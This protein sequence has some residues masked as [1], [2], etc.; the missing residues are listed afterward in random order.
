MPSNS[1]TEREIFVLET[2]TIDGLLDEAADFGWLYLQRGALLRARMPLPLVSAPVDL[3]DLLDLLQTG[4]GV[5]RELA[6]VVPAP[7]VLA[8][9]YDVLPR[10]S[11]GLTSAPGNE[12]AL[13]RGYRA[14]ATATARAELVAFRDAISTSGQ[15]RLVL[16]GTHLAAWLAHATGDRATAL[17]EAS[18]GA[19]LADACGFGRSRSTS[20]C[21]GR[22]VW[23]RPVTSRAPTG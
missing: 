8:A 10:R 15:P 16:A 18:R 1:T 12:H 22:V 11:G 21:C 5:H 13:V 19:E 23:S 14:V 9:L 7:G 20:A 4:S 3:T 17:H 2:Q 6:A